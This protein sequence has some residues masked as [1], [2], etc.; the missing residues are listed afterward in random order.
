M[1]MP[2]FLLKIF[3]MSKIGQISNTFVENRV[4]LKTA[5]I[6]Q[7]QNIFIFKEGTRVT[8]QIC[9][10]SHNVKLAKKIGLWIN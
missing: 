2:K 7:N 10:V 9:E 1:K 5:D 6:F 8:E 3:C 4:T